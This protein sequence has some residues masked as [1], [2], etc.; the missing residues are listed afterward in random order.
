MARKSKTLKNLLSTISSLVV[1]SSGIAQVEAASVKTGNGL[2]VVLQNNTNNGGNIH[3]W[4]ANAV[5]KFLNGDYFLFT[6]A[7]TIRTG[8]VV[9]VGSIDLNSHAAGPFTV[10][11]NTRLGSVV[12]TAGVMV[13]QVVLQLLLLTIILVLVI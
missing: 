2:P 5:T 9:S 12:D 7:V 4:P 13:A 6:N 11:H 10:A 8:S 3:S 1:I